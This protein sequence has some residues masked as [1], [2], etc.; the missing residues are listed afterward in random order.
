MKHMFARTCV[1]LYADECLLS[2]PVFYILRQEKNGYR[3]QRD[4]SDA[5]HSDRVDWKE[6]P[7]DVIGSEL[8]LS[9][10]AQLLGCHPPDL[11]QR[12][13]GCREELVILRGRGDIP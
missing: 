6:M 4:A 10:G 11:R 2:I 3:A 5:M 1:L 9:K 8:T 13:I 7:R 12:C